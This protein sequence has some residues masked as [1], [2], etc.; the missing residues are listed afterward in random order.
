MN[1]LWKRLHLQLS[2]RLAVVAASAWPMRAAGF[3]PSCRSRHD[4][5]S[6]RPC[7]VPCT[8]PKAADSASLRGGLQLGGGGGKRPT[9][10]VVGS[11]DVLR[12]DPRGAEIDAHS[13]V[14]RLNNAPT[15]GW[16][17][18][19][20]GRTSVRVVNHVPIEKWV[21]LARNSSSLDATADGSEYTQRMC[22]PDHSPLGCV[23]TRVHSAPAFR[24]TLGSYRSMHP[25]HRVSLMSDAMHRWGVRCNEE[26]RGTSPSG[27]LYAVLLALASCERPVSLFG[28]WPFCCRGRGPGLPRMNY[29]YFQVRRET[30]NEA[31]VCARL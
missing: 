24:Q 5:E 30:P 6:G 3:A 18:S 28:F 21:R 20:G 23:V 2:K 11:S 22:A 19:V 14:W 27:G 1:Q 4:V 7:V 8:P 31:A 15:T 10:A 16:E 25:S 29:K 9:C 13:V 26:L 12:L 17:R